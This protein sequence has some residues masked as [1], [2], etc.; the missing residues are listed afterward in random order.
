MPRERN[1]KQ[2]RE[3]DTVLTKASRDLGESR[4]NEFIEVVGF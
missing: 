3:G 4:E 2:I 1:L